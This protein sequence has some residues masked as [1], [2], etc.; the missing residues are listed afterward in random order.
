MSV[1]NLS[2]MEEESVPAADGEETRHSMDAT[3][4]GQGMTFAEFTKKSMT[5]VNA[6]AVFA[7]EI[8]QLRRRSIVS[9][10]HLQAG[11]AETSGE[12]QKTIELLFFA[13]QGNLERVKHLVSTHTLEIKDPEMA[14]YDKRTPLHLAASEGSY[15]VCAWLLEQGVDVNA[16][17]RF[18]LTPLACAKLGSH[19]EIAKLLAEKGGQVLSDGVLVPGD[20]DGSHHSEGNVANTAVHGEIED[21][22]W[23]IDYDEISKFKTLGEGAFGTVFLAKWRGTEVAVKQLRKE[24]QVDINSDEGALAEFKTELALM[25]R[26]HHPHVVQFLGT[27][28]DDKGTI[29]IVSERMY[30]SLDKEFNAAEAMT[31]V[32]SL[33]YCLDCAKGLAYLHGRKPMPVIHRD[34]KPA[35]LMLTRGKR[36]KIGDFGLS[37]TLQ[38]RNKL[39]QHMNAVY[40]LT[41]ETGSYRYMAP[42]VFRHEPYGPAIDVYA[43]AM[44][45]Y[46][47]FTW[48]S[49][50][51]GMDAIPAATEAATNKLR[52]NL[53]G[54][55]ITLPPVV[56][57][58]LQQWWT[59]DASL[60]PEMEE[61]IEQLEPALEECKKMREKR[62]GQSACCTIM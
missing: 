54:F 9:G 21:S 58:Y 31:S 29:G 44:I 2:E 4:P 36:L 12:M 43:F 37:R 22:F 33:Q 16:V 48:R 45:A 23:D 17:D 35:N 50:F 19:K 11:F 14:D 62:M 61:I 56:K 7:K 5:K 1:P 27:T 10:V 32:D 52:P 28:T 18:N 40:K 13:S 51:D 30:S 41:G 39:P 53:N 57:T 38:V 46:Q 8:Q 26:L 49:P 15:K 20:L 59:H 47:L 6:A 24:V 60:R 34:L 3:R 25:Q 55:S 42:E